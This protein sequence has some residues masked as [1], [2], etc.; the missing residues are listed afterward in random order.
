MAK[1]VSIFKHFETPKKAGIYHRLVCLT[2]KNKGVA[3]FIMG[4]RAV[5]GRSEDADI[6]ILD[7][8]S[9]REHAEIILVG[10]NYI[11]TDLGSQNGIVVNDLKIT[12]HVLTNGDKIIIGKTVF[13][14]SRIEVKESPK[15]SR[16]RE[17]SHEHE[18]TDDEDFSEEQPKNKLLTKLLFGVITASVLMLLFS[19]TEKPEKTKNKSEVTTVASVDDVFAQQYKKKAKENRESKDKLSY[20]LKRGLR[21]FREGNYFRAITEFESAR[22]WSPNDPL[23]NFYLRR[24]KETL[25]EK[26]QTFLIKGKRD[27]KALNY[28]SAISSYCAVI[29][30]LNDNTSKE[31]LKYLLTA[32][33][34]IKNIELKMNYEEGEIMCISKAKR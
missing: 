33:E 30:L 24:T 20:Y 29:R 19:D 6:R 5:I 12:Q 22:Q 21:E 7:L 31:S 14:F 13:K 25:N 11:V 10:D 4:A 3:Y 27:I 16:E 34:G 15:K 28:N 18:E 8:K 26:I 23:T 9:S 1:A 2:G 17:E 32:K